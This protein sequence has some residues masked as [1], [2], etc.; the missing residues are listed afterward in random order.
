MSTPEVQVK[1]LW[2]RYEERQDWTLK[3]INLT[4]DKGEV[5]AIVG[6][7]EGGKTTLCM[8]LAGLTVHGMRGEFKGQVI[9]SGYDT[10]E[11]AVAEMATKVGTVYQDPESQFIGMSVLDEV[12]F[13]LENLGMEKADIK[14]QLD[15]ALQVVGMEEYLEKSPFELSG[16]QKQKVALASVLAMRPEVLVLDEPTSELDPISRGEVYTVIRD[17]KEKLGRT[18]IWVEHNMEEVV[19]YADRIVLLHD[20]T[21]IRDAKPKEFFQDVDLLLKHGVY[22]PQVAEWAYRLNEARKE[23]LFKSIPLTLD[24]A[25]QTISSRIRRGRTVGQ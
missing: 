8:S 24:E 3:G 25:Y 13:G 7:N 12:V 6:R 14:R 17:L 10:R 9:V 23:V 1:D 4:V 15:W 22:P 16:G 21:I 11:K 19:K 20:G 18:I 2:W 5:V